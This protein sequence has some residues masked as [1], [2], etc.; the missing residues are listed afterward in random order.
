MALWKVLPDHHTVLRQLLLTVSP[1][2][3]LNNRV[4]ISGQML[5]KWLLQEPLDVRELTAQSS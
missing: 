3:V 4:S 5:G 1:M 2:T